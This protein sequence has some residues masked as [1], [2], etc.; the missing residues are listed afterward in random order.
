MSKPET[1]TY[2]IVWRRLIWSVAVCS[3]LWFLAWMIWPA[4][5]LWVL[6]GSAG[7]ITSVFLG[8]AI[9]KRI[10]ARQADAEELEA[11][12]RETIQ[13]DLNAVG[14]LDAATAKPFSVPDDL[15]AAGELHLPDDQD[16]RRSK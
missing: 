5:T 11:E 6:S 13:S 7:V 9:E 12:R 8:A 1:P 3:G 2:F 15:N 16:P 14:E 10:R 4:A